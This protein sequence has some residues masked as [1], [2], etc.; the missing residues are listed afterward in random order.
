MSDQ[1]QKSRRRFLADILFMGGGLTAA[2]LLAKTVSQPEPSS[3]PIPLSTPARTTPAQPVTQQS[4][5]PVAEGEM[6]MPDGDYAMPECES[7][8]PVPEGRMVA[9][10]PQEA[11]PIKGKVKMPEVETN[12]E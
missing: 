3:S 6:V 1:P 5:A 10:P 7:S 11:P 4:P 12:H 9:P 2:A 8:E